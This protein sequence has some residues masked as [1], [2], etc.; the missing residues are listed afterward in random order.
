MRQLVDGAYGQLKCRESEFL[1]FGNRS[2][3]RQSDNVDQ[4][5]SYQ[6]MHS[7]KVRLV[8]VPL[9]LCGALSA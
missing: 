1:L 9:V 2:L 8:A 5:L 3:A 7:A 4:T 6:K